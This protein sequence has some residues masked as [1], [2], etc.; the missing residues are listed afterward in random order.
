MVIVSSGIQV[1]A[2]HSRTEFRNMNLCGSAVLST[3]QQ[4]I[5]SDVMRCLIAISAAILQNTGCSD[6]DGLGTGYFRSEC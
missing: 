6:Q 4:V 3:W 2:C 1:S 5:M